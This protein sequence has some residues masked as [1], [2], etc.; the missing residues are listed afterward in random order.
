MI[1]LPPSLAGAESL[2]RPLAGDSWQ[3]RRLNLGGPMLIFVRKNGQRV[4]I[5]AP[6][7]K[8]PRPKLR[9]VKR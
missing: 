7:P 3:A 5:G 8:R 6:K 9:L 4:A 2:E 1:Q